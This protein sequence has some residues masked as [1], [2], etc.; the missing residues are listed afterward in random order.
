MVPAAL[1][2][3]FLGGLGVHRFYV[4]KIGTGILMIFTLGGLG[5]WLIIDFVM[6][7]TGSFKDKEGKDIIGGIIKCK[8]YKGR[9]TK[10]NK[11]VEVQLNY[12]T[13][14]NPYYGLVD[15]ALRC[16]LFKK[17]STRIELPDGKTA[18]E[19]QINREPEKY[20]T[21]EVM[22]ALESE[23]AKEFKYG[24]TSPKEIEEEIEEK[25]EDGW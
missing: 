23:V 5:I 25:N 10:E 2:C 4:G 1:L 15:I 8:L 19:K 22:W 20:F 9:F 7:L 17:V 24:N 11:E 18:F 21:E 6:I 12:D 16:G 13:G 14:L 3:F